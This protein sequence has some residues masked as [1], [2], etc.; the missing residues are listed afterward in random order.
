MTNRR[1][2]RGWVGGAAAL[3]V[4]LSMGGALAQT[5]APAAGPTL[6]DLQTRL[7]HAQSETELDPQVKQ[8][9]IETYQAAIER[10]EIAD[11]ATLKTRQFQQRLTSVPDELRRVRSKLDLLPG[12][13]TLAVA[14]EDDLDTLERKLGERR[15]QIE[16]PETG[17]R[18]RLDAHKKE[19]MERKSR[20]EEITRDLAELDERLAGIQELMDEPVPDNQPRELT[21]AIQSLLQTRRMRA[22]EERTALHAEQA[23]CESDDATALLRA[24]RD[25]AAGELAL[26][27]AGM[28]M[29]QEAVD[30]RRGSEADQRVRT[31][32]Q[33]VAR[34]SPRVRP[35][36]EVNLALAVESRDLAAA[37]RENNRLVDSARGRF[38][39]LKSEF[40]QSRNM[41]EVVGL[42]E[43]IGLLLRQQRGK[44]SDTRGL[45]SRLALRGEAVRQSRM[46]MFQIEAEIAA[47]QN[48]DAAAAKAAHELISGEAAAGSA[49]KSSAPDAELI[50]Q[51]TGEVKPLLEQRRDLLEGLN[52][53]HGT[54]FEKLVLLDNDERKLLNATQQFAA[55]IDER[56]LWIRTGAVFGGSQ[57]AQ[58]FAGL[59]WLFDVAN[60]RKVGDALLVNFHREPLPYVI[61]LAAL[62]LWAGLR[63]TVRRR[64]RL[65]GT[66]A[67]DDACR[68]M[69]PT[70]QAIALTVLLAAV[71]PAGLA[72][73]GWRLDHCA[74]TSRFVHAVAM[75]L[76]R[77]AAFAVPLELLRLMVVRGG[78]AEK[79]LDWP[80]ATLVRIRRHVNWFIPAG[81][82]LVGLVGMVE[83]TPDDQRLDALGR[84]C[85]LVFAVWLGIFCHRTFP[86][87]P[88]SVRATPANPPAESRDVRRGGGDDSGGVGG[89]DDVWL[90][91][92]MRV[93]AFLAVAIPLGLLVLCWSGY[94]YTALQLTWRLQASAWLA[95]GLVLM[96]GSVQRWLALERRR[97]A[98]LQAE[99]LQ[100]IAG[101]GQHPGAD[102]HSP[103]LF[104]R[105]AWPDFRLNLT[106]IVTQVRSLLDTGL[107]T[108]AA[109]G[110]WLVWA[111]VTPALNILDRITLWQT[112]VSEVVPIKG[113]DDK[114]A[115]QIV[116][117]PKAI[118]AASLGLA[119]VVVL[120][121]VVAG[122]NIPGLVEVILLE[123][124][125]VDAGVRFATTCLVRYAIFIAGMVLAF[126][127][128]G[129]GWNSVQWLVAAASVG[130]GFGLQEI[131]A[132]FVSGII[133]LFE[134]PMRVGDVITIGD[135]TGTVSRI[136]F[137]ATTIV[138]GDR[139]E[140]IVPN[141]SFITGNLLNWTL[142][143]SI[144]R[145][146]I[147]VG[148]AYGS[149]PNRVRELLLKIAS[150]HPSLLKDP[151]PSASLEELG[152]SALV[153]QLKAFLP[154]LKDRQKA[155]HEL[156]TMIHDAFRAAGIVIPFPQQ[157]VSVNFRNPV[158]SAS[159]SKADL[160]EL[161]KTYLHQDLPPTC[162]APLRGGA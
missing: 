2:G 124:L 88:Q 159:G 133:L 75:G 63:W 110:L 117:R 35:V 81:I 70:L 13:P 17:L 27:E 64:L 32:E 22:N 115:V 134:R 41:V 20:L 119:A 76:L 46:R 161:A 157:E 143:D 121:A 131:F 107:L 66:A 89:E 33:T 97:M 31:A 113:A 130:L 108:L 147:R 123:H 43:S 19:L 128:I 52:A 42:T 72:F 152:D 151:A 14:M 53:D 125:S 106:Q 82:V 140:L 122:R 71:V 58:A 11:E 25:L 93:G 138:D 65:L 103:F 145:V 60:W 50:R 114:P 9:V 160:H 51:L 154:N 126:N 18:G 156:N 158:P 38:N 132:N 83:A 153:F 101:A 26:A 85:Y 74:S 100:A 23:W 135:T 90:N 6:A 37:L 136:R 84:L 98:V 94:F 111:D 45:H 8:E 61:A 24:A 5:G 30:K 118:T 150:G 7:K 69:L 109:V 77:A 28:Q 4:L 105:W 95:M 21:N 16:E 80:A 3:V 15:R 12:Q 40:D 36:A 44:L 47:L 112:T 79:H 48:L 139:K 55:Y 92:L 129:V 68:A 116:Q 49:P 73:I 127:Q 34:A 142:S 87:P 78:L 99:E 148:V 86:R 141:K 1:R 54:Q 91:R 120:I 162:L 155:T 102:S 137:R 149:D 56:V 144:N 96:R 39:T 62:M 29:L 67:D 10:L 104:P 59:G 146:A 57:A